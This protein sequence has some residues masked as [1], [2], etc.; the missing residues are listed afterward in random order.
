MK[1]LGMRKGVADLFIAMPHHGYCGAWIELKSES[2]RLSVEQK[3]FL[4]DMK[5]QNYFTAVCRSIESTIYMISWYCE[6][7]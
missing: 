3:E 6:I 7:N 1:D 5:S 2:G 4:E